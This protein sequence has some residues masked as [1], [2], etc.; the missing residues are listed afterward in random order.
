MCLL[1]PLLCWMDMVKLWWRLVQLKGLVQQQ[2]SSGIR[3]CRASSQHSS[4]SRS[5]KGLPLLQSNMFGPPPGMHLVGPSAAL[6]VTR[7]YPRISAFPTGSMCFVSVNCF[8]QHSPCRRT[9]LLFYI[10]RSS[11]VFC[12][13]KEHRSLTF[14]ALKFTRC[15]FWSYFN[16]LIFSVLPFGNLNCW[17]LSVWTAHCLIEALYEI[18]IWAQ[19]GQQQERKCI[20]TEGGFSTQ[21]CS[22]V[23]KSEKKNFWVFQPY[24][25]INTNVFYHG[26][27]WPCRHCKNFIFLLKSCKISDIYA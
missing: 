2:R 4:H 16:V 15:Q 5:L 21:K 20:L 14:A 10:S 3:T 1:A 18:L 12:I 23:F 11:W 22:K 6:F 8:Y 24:E 13:C 19:Q 17:L 25:C 9:L 27:S 26:Q 7:P